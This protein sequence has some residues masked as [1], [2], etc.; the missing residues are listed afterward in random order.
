MKKRL[1]AFILT[2]LIFVTAVCLTGCS[3]RKAEKIT[4]AP[5]S[6]ATGYQV[7]TAL[8]LNGAFIVQ[9]FA[10]DNTKRIQITPDMVSGYD[11]STTGTKTLTVSYNG[12]S[13]T[14][15]YRVYNPENAAKE[16]ITTARLILTVYIPDNGEYAE[17]AVKFTKGDLSGISAATFTM[18]GTESLGISAGKVNVSLS[19]EG[20]NASY[21]SN[22]SGDG[23]KLKILVFEKNGGTLLGEDG[24]LAKIRITGGTNRSVTISD[25]TVSDG[26]Q[27][28]Y[29]PRTA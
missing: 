15:S 23:L 28:Y 10:D 2:I 20:N 19:T 22:L 7:D 16:I 8:D 24:V 5:N 27:N 14:H 3:E 18:T 1:Y 21:E 25:I 4:L 29:L 26:T 17:Y 13:V 6:F 9:H 12:L 11:T